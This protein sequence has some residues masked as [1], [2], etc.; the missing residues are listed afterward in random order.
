M[1]DIALGQGQKSAIKG[2]DEARGSGSHLRLSRHG[3]ML[4]R[5]FAGFNFV[6]SEVK[7]PSFWGLNI[8]NFFLW[9]LET[10]T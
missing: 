7:L 5:G 4:T 10:T 3:N 1:V 9:Q 6:L 2:L 8:I